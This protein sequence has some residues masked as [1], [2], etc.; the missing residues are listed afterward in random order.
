MVGEETLT[1]RQKD[2]DNQRLSLERGRSN[3]GKASIRN[4]ESIRHRWQC[5]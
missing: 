4:Y 1:E 2:S 5:C 3:Y